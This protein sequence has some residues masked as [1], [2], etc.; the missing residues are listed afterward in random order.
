MHY[1]IIA[2]LAFAVSMMGCE[3]KT[4]PAGPTGQ[5]GAVGAAGPQGVAGPAGQTG[6]TGPKGDQGDP[7][8]KGDQGDPGPKGDQGD[9]G[10][11]GDQGDPGPKGDPGER[12]PIGET[13]PP[14]ADGAPGKD[15]A[16]GAP[17]QDGKDGADGAPGKDGADGQ[18]G[19]D[20]APGGTLAAINAISIVRDGDGDVKKRTTWYN[21]PGFTGSGSFTLLAGDDTELVA[22]AITQ[23]ST[24]VPVDFIW[25]SEA[26]GVASVEDGVIT[27][28]NRGETT[29]TATADQRGITIRYEIEVI[30]A[31]ETITIAPSGVDNSTYA[32]GSNIDVMATVMDKAGN[33]ITGGID[34]NWTTTNPDVATVGSGFATTVTIRG[35]GTATI[36]AKVGDKE[37]KNSLTVTGTPFGEGALPG[38]RRMSILARSTLSTTLNADGNAF[39]DADKNALDQPFIYVLYE[40]F[41]PATTTDEGLAVPAGWKPK[42]GVKITFTSLKPMVVKTHNEMAVFTTG[43]LLADGVVRMPIYATKQTDSDV[44]ARSA[45]VVKDGVAQGETETAEIVV[46]APGVDSVTVPFTITR[47]KPPA[48]Q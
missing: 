22:K 20:G 6:A 44:A 26:S 9:P 38:D 19:A 46:S 29:I 18:D 42:D 45:Y 13:G 34:V 14:G 31:V 35:G 3:G 11:K 2:M 37:S 36:K 4:G 24:V 16:D 12:G 41:A 21:A 15:G 39:E 5:T 28:K 33:E 25:E 48:S 10:P 17:G 40:E 30:S 47:L 32:V 23:D 8:P 27:G 1:L 43:G 7:G